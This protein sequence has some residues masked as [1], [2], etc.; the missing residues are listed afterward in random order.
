M[1][2]C[3][4]AQ[5]K[6]EFKQLCDDIR[7]LEA[8][9]SGCKNAL[10]VIN[11]HVTNIRRHADVISKKQQGEIEIQRK[12][13]DFLKSCKDKILNEEVQMKELKEIQRQLTE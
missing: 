9:E 13:Q 10:E 12:L 1:R 2:E 4:R 5:A 6:R 11:S 3:I 8:D 7:E